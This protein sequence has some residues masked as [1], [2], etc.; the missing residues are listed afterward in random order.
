MNLLFEKSFLKD[1]E[2]LK[3]DDIKQEVIEIINLLE[4]IKSFDSINNLKKLKG[5]KT[6]YRI[7]L[8]DY[9]LGLFFENGNLILTRFLHRKDIYKK[10][11]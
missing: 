1:V 3:N 4:E 6:A 10:F 8:G 5:H 9:R 7:R 2:K 11:P